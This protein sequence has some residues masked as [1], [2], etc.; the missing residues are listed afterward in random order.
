MTMLEQTYETTTTTTTTKLTISSA[1]VA[2]AASVVVLGTVP[3]HVTSLSASGEENAST[4]WPPQSEATRPI[5]T[6]PSKDLY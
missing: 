4:V 3:P 2:T 5:G 1:A 6:F